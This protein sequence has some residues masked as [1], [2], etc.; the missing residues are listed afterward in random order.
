MLPSNSLL[1]ITLASCNLEQ[2]PASNVPISWHLH[3]LPWNVG[4][5]FNVSVLEVACRQLLAKATYCS[6]PNS[7]IYIIGFLGNIVFFSSFCS[8]RIARRTNKHSLYWRDKRITSISMGWWRKKQ[9]HRNRNCGDSYPVVCTWVTTEQPV[10]MM[11]IRWIQCIHTLRRNALNIPL[12]HIYY[13]LQMAKEPLAKW[14]KKRES[15][16]YCMKN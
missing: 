3:I 9:M 12:H 7:Q 2:P 5:L 8:F 13:S 14:S 15:L 11:E 6:Y 16:A 4:Y 10:A 1:S